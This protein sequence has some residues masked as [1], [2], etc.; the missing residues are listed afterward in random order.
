MNRTSARW[1]ARTA[2]DTRQGMKFSHG[3]WTMRDGVTPIYAERVAEH[4]IRD[5]ALE[6]VCV[7][8][9]LSLL[10]AR[11]ASKLRHRV[12]HLGVQDP[13]DPG[14]DRL[15]WEQAVGSRVGRLDLLLRRGH[16]RFP[17]TYGRN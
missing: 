2:R 9:R 7:V 5:N 8:D 3:V 15:V 6:L 14:T 11:V 13:P 16:G 10:V 1:I 12:I 4:R 17:A